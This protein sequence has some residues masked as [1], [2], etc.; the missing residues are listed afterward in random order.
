MSNPLV[1]AAVPAPAP[2]APA[3]AAPAPVP[4]FAP[5]PA[6]APTT[7]VGM[8]AP[9]PAPQAAPVAVPPTAPAA[10]VADPQLAA[11]Q[12]TVQALAAQ[13]RNQQR[14]VQL[15]QQAA[16]GQ[17]NQPA[18]AQ[19]APA[20]PAN[21]FGMPT[22]D[23]NWRNLLV[24]DENGNFQE[25]PG[26]PMGTLQ[27]YLAYQQQLP[28]ALGKLLNDPAGTLG[29]V[30]EKLIQEKAQQIAQETIGSYENRQ[31]MNNI[32]SEIESWAIAK[33][34]DGSPMMAYDHTG[35]LVE[36]LTPLGQEY[37]RA[38]T[39]A[40]Q[41]GMRDPAKVHQYAKTQ[42]EL[43]KARMPAAPGTPAA[44]A[45]PVPSLANQFTQPGAAFPQ[46]PNRTPAPGNVT[47]PST[48]H[49]A[50]GGVTPTSTRELLLHAAK[51]QGLIV[52]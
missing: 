24:Q 2:A 3:P 32:L 17:L 10:P 20:Q 43:A 7:G 37:A 30:L 6:P 15:G 8:T 21:P 27:N 39:F 23:P 34:A 9:A 14:Y 45:A 13:L 11:A 25:R 44:P 49:P 19:P 50:P 4:A 12:A 29:P 51:V 40:I 16:A 41:G 35:Q 47:V 1:P 48:L 22:F 31:V 26:A 46:A 28:N 52:G 38:S 5:V 36:Q 33:N 18:V 42:V